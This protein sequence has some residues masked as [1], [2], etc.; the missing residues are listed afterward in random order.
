M[1]DRDSASGSDEPADGTKDVCRDFLRNVC[2]RGSRCRFRHPDASVPDPGVTKNEFIFCHDFQN[3]ECVHLNCKFIHGTRQDE[4]YYKKTG[5]LPPHLHQKVAANLGLLPT[6]LPNSKE[7]VPICRDYLKGGCLRG[8]K[9]KFRHIQRENECKIDYNYQFDMKNLNMESMA[10]M[11]NTFPTVNRPDTFVSP[12]MIN[13]Y[14]DVGSMLKRRRVEGTQVPVC[15]YGLAAV[16]TPEHRQLEEE[17]I[18]LRRRVE[19]LKKQVSILQ[20]SNEVLLEQN[21]QFRQHQAK[22]V[23]LSLAATAG[24]MPSVVT[25]YNHG[26]AQTHTTLSTHTLQ[27]HL[28]PKHELVTSSPAQTAAQVGTAN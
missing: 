20:A 15:D 7:E 19:E 10:L 1:P 21:A 2:Y 6:D 5:E 16:R 17:A 24:D 8:T 13:S 3:K 28:M 26:L 11:Q 12:Y 9:C 4:D 18:L 14:Q 22:I 23:T 25:N 27:P